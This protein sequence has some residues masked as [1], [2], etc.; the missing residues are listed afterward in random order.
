MD[1]SGPGE[2]GFR[3]KAVEHASG[4]Y[5][6][7]VSNCARLEGWRPDQAEGWS[8]AAADYCRRSGLSADELVGKTQFQLSQAVDKATFCSSTG[9]F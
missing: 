6:A 9:F 5:L 8:E 2:R 1:A 3:R 7:S 4:A